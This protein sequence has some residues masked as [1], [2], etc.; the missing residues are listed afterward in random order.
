MPADAERARPELWGPRPAYNSSV[1]TFRPIS[2]VQAAV[3]IALS[4]P[5][6][7]GKAL[8][9][10]SQLHRRRSSFDLSRDAVRQALELRSYKGDYTL[11]SSL[12]DSG[13]PER[14]RIAYQGPR[15]V[16]WCSIPA[17]ISRPS[18]L[19]SAHWQ[20]SSAPPCPTPS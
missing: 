7:L 8:W 5:V 20:L 9:I 12:F 18:P 10:G 14:F 3:R 1:I 19:L 17:A 16:C 11:W 13:T 4:H 2:R 15:L 6:V